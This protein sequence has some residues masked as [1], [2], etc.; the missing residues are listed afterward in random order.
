MHAGDSPKKRCVYGIFSASLR[1]Q[2]VHACR[3]SACDV[4]GADPA[5]DIK[6]GMYFDLRQ[7]LARGPGLAARVVA[8]SEVLEAENDH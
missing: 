8:N 7:S 6:I 2:R 1:K 4:S 5:K 3:Q